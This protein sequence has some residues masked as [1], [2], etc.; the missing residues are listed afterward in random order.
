MDSKMVKQIPIDIDKL[1]LNLDAKLP[2]RRIAYEQKPYLELWTCSVQYYLAPIRKKINHTRKMRLAW[3]AQ[4]NIGLIE[5][6]QPFIK[7]KA[8]FELIRKIILAIK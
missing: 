2:Q 8:K 1:I 4:G 5:Y 7:N 3:L 6:I